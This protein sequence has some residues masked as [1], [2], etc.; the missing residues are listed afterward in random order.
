MPAFK[1]TA[2]MTVTVTVEVEVEAV[3]LKAAVDYTEENLCIGSVNVEDMDN[4]GNISL[5]FTENPSA[6]ATESV[7]AREKD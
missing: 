1:L 7:K 5:R 3:S 4:P 6:W 2:D